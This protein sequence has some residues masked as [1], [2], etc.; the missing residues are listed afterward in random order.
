MVNN[1]EK[2]LPSLRRIAQLGA[3][4]V[5]GISITGFLVGTRDSGYQPSMR[6]TYART[7]ETP[8]PTAAYSYSELREVKRGPNAEW[9]PQIAEMSAKT[10]PVAPVID[11]VL[12]QQSLAR[13]SER[14]AYNGAPPV[15]PHP[16]GSMQANDCMI[17]HEGGLQLGDQLAPVLS[18]EFHANCLQ[19]HSPVFNPLLDKPA[20]NVAN[21]FQGLPAPETGMRAWTGAP[22]VMPHTTH[23]RQ[24]CSSCHGVNGWPGIQTTHPERQNCRQCHGSQAPL[25]QHVAT[26]QIDASELL[27]VR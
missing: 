22:P 20:L 7:A 27:R 1:L 25:E 5:I 3:M 14:R 11:A 17:C 4:L 24:N 10:P 16:V 13:R 6:P 18:H 15:V 2:K 8:K 26:G 9:P 19:C 21:L 12:K 23:M